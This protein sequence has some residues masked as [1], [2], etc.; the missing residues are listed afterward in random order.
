MMPMTSLLAP[1]HEV[2]HNLFGH[3]TSLAPVSASHN[4]DGII[5]GTIT[6]SLGQDIQ[7]EVHH[8]L[9]HYVMPLAMAL[10]SH[11]ANNII[12]CITAF[13]RSR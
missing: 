13:L 4:A 2:Q 8:D 10:V 9:F 5:N 11:D 3:V 12:N 7:N 1:L 6:H